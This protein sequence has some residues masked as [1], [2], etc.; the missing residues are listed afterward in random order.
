MSLERRN[1]SRRSKKE[2][3]ADLLP[4]WESEARLG[5]R[6]E[7]RANVLNAAAEAFVKGGY[8]GT[9]LDDVAALLGTTKGQIY[10]YYRSKSDLFFDVA[11]GG[12]FIVW[13]QARDIA[14]RNDLS[15]TQRLREVAHAHALSIVKHHAF[16]RIALEAFQ[17]PISNSISERQQR[18]R[19][20]IAQLR[21]Q[22]ESC[23]ADIIREG[24][25]TGEFAAASVEMATNAALGS[26][27]WMTIW[28]DPERSTSQENATAIAARVADFVVA[29][30]KPM[31]QAPAEEGAT[32]QPPS[33]GTTAASEG[34]DD[35]SG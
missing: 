5:P 30:L 21:Q 24:I 1:S 25:A 32:A 26:L 31:P 6:L 14:K 35:P 28:F 8:A 23:L 12:L 11:V 33:P 4:V 7:R 22:Y 29:G 19:Q 16:Q 27:N 20:H 9:T 10:H 18:A 2:P 15:A 13:E 17:Y 34:P 3:T